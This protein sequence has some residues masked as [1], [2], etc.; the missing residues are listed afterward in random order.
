M[1]RINKLIHTKF[2]YADL[3]KI[4][5]YSMTLPIIL[6]IIYIVCNLIFGT[7]IEYFK[8]AYDAIS[9]IYLITVMLM[10]K[11]DIIKNMQELQSVLEEQKKV[12]EE[13]KKEKE[14]QKEK[15]QEEKNNDEEKQP[16]PEEKNKDKKE[17]QTDNG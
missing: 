13:L 5:I 6:Y 2:R 16:E 12:R 17:P 7:T 9:Y 8:I 3:F 11:A 15:K 10:L 14:E 4:S 1:K